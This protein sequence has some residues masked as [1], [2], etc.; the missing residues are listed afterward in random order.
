M[1]FEFRK[2][3]T[4]VFSALA[5]LASAAMIHYAVDKIDSAVYVNTGDA[6]PQGRIVVLDC[7]HGGM[8]GGLPPNKTS[9]HR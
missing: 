6:D 4:A 1:S 3:R 5:V 9:A 7:G 2:Y 8:D